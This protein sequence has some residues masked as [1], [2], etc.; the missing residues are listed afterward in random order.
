ML[1]GLN[2]IWADLW[3]LEVADR[4][5]AGADQ[6]GV[7][8]IGRGLSPNNDAIAAPIT[9]TSATSAPLTGNVAAVKP[10]QRDKDRRHSVR[11]HI[12]WSSLLCSFSCTRRRAL[13]RPL[14]GIV[15]I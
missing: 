4:Q 10:Q 2:A 8:G 13:Y 15:P 3:E 7:G 14:M 11:D 9:P 5:N 1:L 6:G 12:H